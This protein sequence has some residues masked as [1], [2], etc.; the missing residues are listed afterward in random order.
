MSYVG[1]DE[2]AGRLL[3]QIKPVLMAAL[4]AILDTFYQKTASVPELAEKFA[5]PES[6]NA[7]KKAQERHWSHLFDG[8]FDET[9]RESAKTIGRTHH[10]IG[11]TP[12]WYLLGYGML[13]GELLAVV[14]AEQG[15]LFTP[16]RRQRMAEIQKAV[17]RAVIIDMDL[18]LSSYWHEL[19]HER[20]RDAETMIEQTNRQVSDTVQSVSHYTK[21]LLSSAQSMND[22]STAVSGNAK[23]ASSAAE[24]AVASAQSVAA[25]AEELHASIEEIARHVVRS[26]E[27]SREAVGR[28]G[29]V[30]DVVGHLGKAAEEIGQVVSLIGDIASQT[31]LLALNATIEAARAGEAGKG[32]S[33]VAAEV[34]TLANQSGQSAE[35]ISD[36]IAKMQDVVRRTESSIEEVETTIRALEEIATSISAAVEEQT[37]A[38]GEI[39]QSVAQAADHA[40][41]VSQ[42]MDS[43][44][45]RVVN[46]NEAS[47]AVQ[48]CTQSLDDVMGTLGRLLTKAVR[49]SSAIADRRCFRRRA[50]MV[51]AEMKVSNSREK[52]VVFDLSEGGAL[53][54]FAKPLAKG[55]KVEL[56]IPSDGLRTAGSIVG[57]GDGLCHITFDRELPS[58]SVRELG[59]K[60][61]ARV[62]EV[63]KD[64][65][66]AFVARISDAVAGKISYG[67]AE[68]TTHHT[69]RLGRWYDTVADEVLA[70]LPSFKALVKPHAKIHNTGLAVLTAVQD[71]NSEVAQA[72]L[73]D[74][75]RLSQQVIGALDA[76]YNEMQAH[77]RDEKTIRK[78]S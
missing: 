58:E 34:K 16:A 51:D 23:S 31:N 78:A 19:D 26:S 15:A 59:W 24:T 66:R 43:V 5:S 6:M 11:L 29:D 41:H 42:M 38:T 10:R 9:Y 47:Y 25:G 1:F 69:C 74:L 44:L 55:T 37:A 27:T 54:S 8:E 45:Q 62:I 63:T 36:R 33:V 71:G 13:L 73:A 32:F 3:R 75:E 35:Q 22:V 52:I 60:Y 77:Y 57:C 28:M 21:E 17:S 53:V 46:A 61:F 49:T 14:A 56:A 40:G 76:V 20:K 12:S 30:R 48:D 7:A 64:D 72:R 2:Q 39:A 70:D 68:L 65:H 4:P 50:L 18:A 67:V